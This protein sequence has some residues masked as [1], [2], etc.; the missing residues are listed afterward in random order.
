VS[1]N[2]KLSKNTVENEKMKLKMKRPKGD[3]ER[4]GRDQK[5]PK[6]Q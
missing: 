5:E 4:A 3:E 6:D 2:Q 1:H